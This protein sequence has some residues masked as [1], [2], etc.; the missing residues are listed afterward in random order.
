MQTNEA[1]HQAAREP[2]DDGAE[3]ISGYQVRL[4][5]SYDPATHT[6]LEEQSPGRVRVGLDPLEIEASGTVAALSLVPAGSVV[7]RCASMGSLEAEKFVGPLL[8]PLSGTVVA[9]NDDL[10]AQ[11]SEL[12]RDP[13]S[14]WLVE[15]DCGDSAP[16]GLVSG[17]AQVREWFEGQ[18]AEY[19]LK[20]VLAE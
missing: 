19:R 18:V 3:R 1:D 6:W 7:E 15:I 9:V 10:L 5:V 12:D 13:Y 16:I 11:P 8:S 17:A 2:E 14:A 4:D 20:G